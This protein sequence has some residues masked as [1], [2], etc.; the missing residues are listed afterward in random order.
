MK[1]F[2]QTGDVLTAVAP[3]AVDSGEFIVV[4]AVY[5]VAGYAAAIG[6]NVE[7]HRRGVFKDLPKTAGTAWAFGDELFWDAAAK[8]FTKDT[9][10]LSIRAVAAAAALAGDAVGTVLLDAPGGLKMAAGVHET[11]DADDTIVTG[12]SAVVA[13]VAT[14]ESDPVAGA[15]SATATI[16]DQAGAPAA[17]SIQIK[18]WKATAAGDTA[19]IAAT[20]F[21]KKV[22]W[23]AVGV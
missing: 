19:L 4:G 7:L 15:Q 13:V 17:G 21:G 1:N 14:L 11:I 6:E 12:L 22:N 3:E 2:V 10:K 5:G 20:T 8:T 18:T 16:G 23:I 9:T